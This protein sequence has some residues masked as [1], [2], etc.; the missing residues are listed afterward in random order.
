MFQEYD[1]AVNALFAVKARFMVIVPRFL[2]LL[3]PLLVQISKSLAHL[4][5]DMSA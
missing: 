5:V 1:V 4:P 2:R 3:L